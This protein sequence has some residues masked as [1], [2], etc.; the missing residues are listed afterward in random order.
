ML[1]IES[2]AYPLYIKYRYLPFRQDIDIALSAMKMTAEREEVIDFVAPYYE[3]TG[4]LIG[5]FSMNFSNFL[6]FIDIFNF[7]FLY[8]DDSD[9]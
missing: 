8:H 4:I 7:F 5:A 3:T 6:P 9:P 2:Y 1:L